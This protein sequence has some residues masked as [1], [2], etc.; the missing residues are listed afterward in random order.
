M[1]HTEILIS[2]I[3]NC[4][5]KSNLFKTRNFVVYKNAL[6]FVDNLKLFTEEN[7]LFSKSVA[8]VDGDVFERFTDQDNLELGYYL[9]PRTRVYESIHLNSNKWISIVVGQL[10]RL[11]KKRIVS[12]VY[13]SY[14][15]DFGLGLHYDQWH[16]VIL[17]TEGDKIWDIYDDYGNKESIH[18]QKGDILLLPEKLKHEVKT[19]KFSEHIVFAF[20]TNSDNLNYQY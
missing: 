16:G 4:V 13:V 7:Q 17:Q 1:Q 18:L 12:T 14:E 11:S 3:W 15:T 8:L 19:P 20:L 9:K 5:L 2:I 6:S 10:S